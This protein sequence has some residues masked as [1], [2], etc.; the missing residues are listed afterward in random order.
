[1]P[2]SSLRG[3]LRR[4]GKWSKFLLFLI[5]KYLRGVLCVNTELESKTFETRLQIVASFSLFRDI[6]LC[7]VKGLQVFHERA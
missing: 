2:P 7:G 5:Q 1:M 4:S 6:G 3:G